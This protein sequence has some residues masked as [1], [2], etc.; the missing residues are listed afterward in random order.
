[1]RYQVRLMVTRLWRPCRNMTALRHG[2]AQNL[3][4]MI[5]M[6]LVIKGSD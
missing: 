5:A 6:F 3:H 4:L 1:M 2:D